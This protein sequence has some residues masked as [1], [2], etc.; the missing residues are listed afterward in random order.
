MFFCGSN[1]ATLTITD[2]E[3]I[4]SL[5]IQIQDLEKVNNIEQLTAILFEQDTEGIQFNGIVILKGNLHVVR[6]YDNPSNRLQSILFV[7]SIE[8]QSKDEEIENT[9]IDIEGF[10]QFAKESRGGD[11]S[12]IDELVSKAAPLTV[13]NDLAKKAML[14]VTVNAGLPNDATRLPK[15]I[16]SNVGLIG[17]PGL[18]KTQVLHQFAGLVPGS[19]VE[20][21]QSG[22]PVSMTVYI[23]KE[24]NGQR[25][26]RP[27]PVVLASGAILGLNE[28]GQMKNIE[29]NKYFTDSA[30][31]GSFTVTKHGFNIHVTAHPSFV[32]T[33][34]PVSGRWKNPG[35]IDAVE[36]PILAQWGDRMDFI[37][38]FIE[39]TDETSI[40]DYAKQRRELETR[41]DSFASSSLWLKKYLLYARNL[42]PDLPQ[43]VR[44][45]LE[46]Y[47][48]DIAKQG[49]R[50]LPRRLEALERTAIGFAKLKLKDSVDEEDAS[51]T[52]D[53]FNEIL[54]FYKQ[55]VNSPRDLV[56]LQCLNV[57]E[58]T[59]P[60]EWVLDDL[61]QEVSS[62]NPSI[63]LYIG[64][65]KKSQY[66]YKIKALKPLFN[67]HPNV[68][69]SNENPTTYAW[70]NR[71]DQIQSDTR[72]KHRGYNNYL[73]E[74]SDV[75]DVTATK[76]KNDEI[77]NTIYSNGAN[78]TG[79]PASAT[80]TVT[81]SNIDFTS[82]TRA[83]TNDKKP[84][85]TNKL[86]SDASDA[87]DDSS[88]TITNNKNI[89]KIL[90]RYPSAA[91]IFTNDDV[92][93][94]DVQ[95]CSTSGGGESV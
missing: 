9:D 64:E 14:I 68:H 40:R 7:E 3:Y 93:D 77:E 58:K 63:D 5:E 21:M 8:K 91:H 46:N 88:G 51:D 30:E 56:F 13:G 90:L 6:K 60:K 71:D 31:E 24:E 81:S 50:G 66:N 35:V 79:T 16:R 72:E 75:T 42:K 17:D 1:G 23:D 57:L 37:I 43:N 94:A 34:N 85:W 86:T 19:R 61:I 95:N 87:S 38:P 89:E 69:R 41:L 53:L 74:S 26:M 27:G 47:L 32:W 2:Y 44:I 39:R 54:K 76:N 10:Q 67:K 78:V 84:V 25:T 65:V 4:A 33:A 80:S 48:V 83:N 36:F 70:F 28:F 12:L 20:S 55:E 22:T 15:R 59:S 45:I 52:I 11:T 29:D 62:K 49:V 82:D 18:A 73:E 92:E